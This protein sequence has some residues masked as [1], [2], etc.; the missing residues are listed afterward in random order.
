MLARL[1][2]EEGR[3]RAELEGVQRAIAALEEA[4]GTA[5]ASAPQ[6]EPAPPAPYAKSSLY[7]AVADYLA[8]AGQP[9][10]ARQI[11]EAL[12]AGGVSDTRARLCGNGAHDVATEPLHGGVRNPAQ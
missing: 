11:A 4:L 6:P 1:R 3:L 7:R 10:T 5:S 9:Q 8:K 12:R 2:E